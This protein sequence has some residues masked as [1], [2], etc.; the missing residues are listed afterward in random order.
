[1][2]VFWPKFFSL[3]FWVTQKSTAK[4]ETEKK[5][6]QITPLLGSDHSC[7]FGEVQSLKIAD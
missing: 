5:P 2:Y 6:D 3:T 7:T 1:M 4:Y